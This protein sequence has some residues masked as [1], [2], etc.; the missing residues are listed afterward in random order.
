M[1]RATLFCYL[2]FTYANFLVLTS[3]GEKLTDREVDELLRTVEISKDGSVNYQGTACSLSACV[4][5]LFRLDFVR[6][7]I[8][9]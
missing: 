8:K 3:L 5:S 2:L 7:I 1:V 9:G 6:T 4:D